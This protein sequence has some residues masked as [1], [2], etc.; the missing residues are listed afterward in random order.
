MIYSRKD[1]GAQRISWLANVGV[2]RYDDRTK[3]MELGAGP[4]MPKKKTEKDKYARQQKK[5]RKFSDRWWKF[6][7]A[8][9]CRN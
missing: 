1:H 3:G 8:K 5:N 2:V 9:D 6:D 4:Y 7:F